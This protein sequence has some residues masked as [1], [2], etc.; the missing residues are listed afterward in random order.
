LSKAPPVRLVNPFKQKASGG[1]IYF[2]KHQ[3]K[4]KQELISKKNIGGG[5]KWL[6]FPLRNHNQTK[7]NLFTISWYQVIF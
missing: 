5:K 7:K 3:L 1:H 6:V 4:K 2:P